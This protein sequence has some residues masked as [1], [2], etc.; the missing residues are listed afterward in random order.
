VSFH[1]FEIH[2]RP[3]SWFKKVDYFLNAVDLDIPAERTDAVRSA[4]NLLTR[5]TD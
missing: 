1:E 3:L 4:G 2:C 5:P